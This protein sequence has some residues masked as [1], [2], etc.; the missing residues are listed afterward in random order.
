MRNARSLLFFHADHLNIPK[1]MERTS[2]LTT[3]MNCTP[4]LV[5][6]SYVKCAVQHD[7]AVSHSTGANDEEELSAKAI[8]GPDG[9][10]SKDNSKG[11]VEGIY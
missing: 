7:H 8:N 4:Q 9:I 3:V 1:Y 5:V 11:G 10:Q 2:H 6:R